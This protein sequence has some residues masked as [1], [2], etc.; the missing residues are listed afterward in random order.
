MAMSATRA[1][2]NRRR[3]ALLATAL[4]ALLSVL[5]VGVVPGG[6]GDAV[7]AVDRFGDRTRLLPQGVGFSFPFLEKRLKV[8]RD[9]GAAF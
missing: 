6:S 4:L 8:P 7:V 1:T 9:A 2:P 3:I 5:A